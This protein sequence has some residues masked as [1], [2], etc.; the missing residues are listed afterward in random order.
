MK[1]IFILL[2]IVFSS[3]LISKNVLAQEINIEDEGPMIAGSGNKPNIV[4]LMLDDVNPMD[5]RFFKEGRTPHIYNN[6]ISKGINFT[7]FYVE[8]TL[9]CPARAGYLTGIHTQNHGVNDLDGTK[10]NPQVTLATETRAAGYYTIYTG[11]YLNGYRDFPKSLKF[12]PGWDKFDV[13]NTNNGKFYDYQIIHKNGNTDN[14]GANAADYSTDVIAG[15]TLKRIKEAPANKPLLIFANPYSIH[16]P[17]V[18]APRHIGD[19]RCK[20]IAKWKPLDYNE[21]DRSDKA[22]WIQD[23]PAVNA[24]GYDVKNECEM[25]L[26]SDDLLGKI[27]AELKRQGRYHNTVFILT[28]DNGYGFGEHRIPAK[29]SPY[30]THVPF[31]IS[32]AAGRGTDPKTDSTILSNI[33]VAPTI[34]EIAGCSMG[35][36]PNGQTTPD[37]LSFASLI[38]NLPL[39]HS[40]DSILESQP[41]RPDGAAPDTRPAWWALR[42]TGQSPEGL[43]HY[44]EY[45]SGEKELYDLSNG[46]C[47]KWNQTMTGDPCELRNLL[48]H[49]PTDP[50]VIAKQTQFSTRLSQLKTEKGYGNYITITPTPTLTISPSFSS[51]PSTTSVIS[52]TE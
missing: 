45:D 22:K 9:C 3:L 40:R 23:L 44:I 50:N 11:K 49:S 5:G 2:L 12:P 17:H 42:T 34:C 25:L 18:V 30:V 15:W 19:E 46:P 8:T 10:F 1:K 20:H 28:A 7:N 13:F 16:K 37:G 4:I 21:A 38:K 41:V 26:S 35:P 14:Y 47:Y 39:T 52:P 29:T 51:S 43:W 27:V 48:F 6:V 24:D 31:Y 33:D 36:Y 32:W